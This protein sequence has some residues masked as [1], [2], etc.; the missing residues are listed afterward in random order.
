MM[1]RLSQLAGKQ[2]KTESGKLIG[3]VHEVR[4]KDGR[5]DTLICGA[6]GFLQRLASTLT[7]RRVKWEHVRRITPNEIICRD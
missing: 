7:G 3:R 6:E 5:I 1:L 2:I 4:A